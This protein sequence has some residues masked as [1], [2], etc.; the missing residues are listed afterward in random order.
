MAKRI[1][2]GVVRIPHH[3][4]SVA[5]V[6]FFSAAAVFGVFAGGHAA[7]AFKMIA[8]S[9][10]FA[11]E[12]VNM[13]GNRQTSEIDILG[14]LGLDGETSLINF[15]VGRAR[16]AIAALPWVA[17]VSV[18]KM[19]PDHLDIAIVEREPAAV[20]QHERMLDIIDRQ[21]H[22][23][24]PYAAAL[25]HGLPLLVGEGAETEAGAFL[26]E[27]RPF[28]GIAGHARA[29]IRIGGRRWDILLDNGVRI[30]LP[31]TGAPARLAQA[32]AI[33]NRDGLFSRDVETVDLRLKDRITLALSK[34]ALE[35]RMA[36]VRDLESR[37]KAW[38]AGQ[39]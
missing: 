13:S 39:V 25:A 32:L 29:Y 22:V 12:K 38:K 8:V 30:K 27:M 6:V 18:R 19:Y 23:I 33:E 37:E 28:P 4:G 36:A 1:Q 16:A 21:G 2:S 14:A 31:E 20:W 26:D 7:Q 17:S 10:G 11:V 9:A 15:D 3:C 34:E 5:V 24:V 35:R